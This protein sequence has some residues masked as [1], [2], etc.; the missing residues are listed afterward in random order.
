[1]NTQIKLKQDSPRCNRVSKT[2]A[3]KPVRVSLQTKKS[4]DTM[5][6]TINN[7]KTGKRLKYDDIIACAIAKLTDSDIDNLR[8]SMISNKDRF[9]EL[10][11]T[12]RKTNKLLTKDELLGLLLEGSSVDN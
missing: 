9:E 1:M 11:R 8:N 7:K 10:Y 2:E 6:K 5:V 3:T 12:Q 4:L